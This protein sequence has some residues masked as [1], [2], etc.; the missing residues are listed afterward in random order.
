MEFRAVRLRPYRENAWIAYGSERHIGSTGE[1]IT[2]TRLSTKKKKK[3][4]LGR[5]AASSHLIPCRKTNR[6]KFVVRIVIF[7]IC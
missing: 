4:T 5:D 7:A 1:I 3:K 6:Y 2:T